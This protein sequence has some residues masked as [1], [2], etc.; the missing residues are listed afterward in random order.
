MPWIILLIAGLLEVG[1]SYS[2]KLSQ[3][4]TRPG[5]AVIT[6]VLMFASVALLSLA[7]RTLPLGTA[8][9]VWTGIGA[10]GAFVLGIT[11]LGEAATP[12][13][14]LAALLIVAGLLLMKMASPH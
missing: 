5:M 10:I 4:F 3:G 11:V 14:L 12:M 9:T 6:L 13:R 7:M 1:W 8:Y 2:M